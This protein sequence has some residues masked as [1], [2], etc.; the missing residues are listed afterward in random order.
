[1]FL[2][3]LSYKTSTNPKNLLFCLYLGSVSLVTVRGAVIHV[4]PYI[5]TGLEIKTKITKALQN[6]FLA[7]YG[8]LMM[9]LHF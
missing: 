2:D 6:S 9:F 7:E 4:Q 3:I 5:Y 8:N 1:M